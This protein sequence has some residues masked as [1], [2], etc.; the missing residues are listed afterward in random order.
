[1]SIRADNYFALNV[2]VHPLYREFVKNYF[3]HDIFGP[4]SRFLFRPVAEITSEIDKFTEEHFG[5]Y[6]IGRALTGYF[7]GL[8]GFK[9]AGLAVVSLM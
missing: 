4:L 2:A 5:K 1:V 8:K 7:D 3:G 9:Y 6:T